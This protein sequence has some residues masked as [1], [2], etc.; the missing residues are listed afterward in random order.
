MPCATG[1]TNRA[2]DDFP[3]VQHF[4]EILVKDTSIDVQQVGQTFPYRYDIIQHRYYSNHGIF[5]DYFIRKHLSNQFNI[6]IMDG[7]TEYVL[8]NPDEF[9]IGS[10]PDLRSAISRHY[11]IFKDPTTFAMN[12]IKSIKVVSL[13]HTI[14][15]HEELPK[16]EYDINEDNLL[17]V[18]KYF[19]N[20]SYTMVTLNPT[21]SC[22]YFFADADLIMDNEVM[23][24]IK[25]SR[26]KSLKFNE[27]E[28]QKDT[29][30]QTI[31]YGFGF[32]KRTGKI[33]KKF[34]IYNPLLGYEYSME[35]ND[36]DFVLFEKVLKRDT[37]AYCRLREFI[38][39]NI[40]LDLTLFKNDEK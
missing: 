18:I 29:F 39:K 38:E 15:F 8:D 20:L 14:F 35:L 3:N 37:E 1:I 22:E 13:A 10:K 16:T 17:E 40:S 12:I 34:K 36:I 27:S 25:T 4:L 9:V 32:Y 21:L 6:E 19:E 11:E 5:M 33:I 7:R 28:I 23:Y 2:L 31:I 24:E 26:F 30:Y